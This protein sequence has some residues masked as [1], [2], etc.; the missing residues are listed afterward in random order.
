M[1]DLIE[2]AKERLQ[3]A[4]Q[5]RRVQFA[6]RFCKE[7]EGTPF[8]EWDSSHETSVILPDGTRYRGY[9][10]HRHSADA[11]LDN[12]APDLARALIDTTAER[13][14]I[15][16]AAIQ[17]LRDVEATAGCGSCHETR[18]NLRADIAQFRRAL[19]EYTPN[20]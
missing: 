10:V 3:W 11:E 16:A 12:M 20:D 5:G 14:K 18:D 6:P 13:D 4:T 7:A 8:S 2:R 1:T 15:K 9:S 19:Q 17:F